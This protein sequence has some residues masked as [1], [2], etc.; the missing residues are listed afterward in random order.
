M[1]DKME[2]LFLKVSSVIPSFALLLMMFMVVVEVI[3][4]EIFGYSF[5]VV[6]ELTGYLLVGIVF[7]G[8]TYSFENGSFVK[9]D[10]LYSRFSPKWKKSMDKLFIILLIIYTSILTYYIIILNLNSFY[11]KSSSTSILRTPLYLPQF[12]MSFGMIVFILYLLI[13]LLKLFATSEKN[14]LGGE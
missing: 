6:H 8:V 3:S 11:L 1:L 4:R 9:I 12:L 13:V 2:K 10:M 5:Q 7:V 14:A